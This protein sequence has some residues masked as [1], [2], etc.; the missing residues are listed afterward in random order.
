MTNLV[1]AVEGGMEDWAY[2]AGWENELNPYQKPIKTCSPNTFTSYAVEKTTYKNYPIRSIMYLVE[3]YYEKS[4]NQA[5]FGESETV[6]DN[7]NF[8]G[9]IPRNIRLSLAAIDMLSPYVLFNIDSRNVRFK[10]MGC[11]SVETFEIIVFEYYNSITDSISNPMISMNKTMENFSCYWN[12]YQEYNLNDFVDLEKKQII[13]FKFRTDSSWFNQDKPDP[14]IPPQSL[15]VFIRSNSSKIYSNPNYFIK[16]NDYFLSNPII[17][18]D[19]RE[20]KVLYEEELSINNLELVVADNLREQLATFEI[21]DFR[22]K[23]LSLKT[24]NSLLRNVNFYMILD[25]FSNF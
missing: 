7:D 22:N 2:A 8:M 16:G 4:P 17:I 20:K 6:L 11:K 3:T 10:L 25:C 18:E 24:N 15:A 1:Y 21:I 12:D 14:N 9:H 23:S 5:D 13:F 19:N